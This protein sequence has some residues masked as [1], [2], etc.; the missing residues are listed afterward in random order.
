MKDILNL[1]RREAEH[2]DGHGDGGVWGGDVRVLAGGSEGGWS[3]GVG[4]VRD[5]MGVV[6]GL[7]RE[8]ERGKGKVGSGEGK[9]RED[10]V[11]GRR[12]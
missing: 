3:G 11:Y 6:R 8:R 7:V 9:R 5:Q 12:W 2:E 4:D 1:F 10:E